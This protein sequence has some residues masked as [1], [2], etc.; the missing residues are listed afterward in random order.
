MAAN[1]PYVPLTSEVMEFAQMYC[2]NEANGKNVKN[3][4]KGEGILQSDCDEQLLLAIP[5]SSAVR[6]FSIIVEGPAS[7]AP[8]H[9]K[10]FI[11]QP[12][13]D[14]QNAESTPAVQEISL[15]PQQTKEGAG[16]PIPLRF[17]KFQNVNRLLIF[18]D[19]NHGGEDQ[20]IISRLQVIGSPIKVE[21]TR[22][23]DGHSHNH[24]DDN[25]DHDL[26]GQM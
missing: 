15:T 17:V 24:D 25:T 3:L 10:I 5:Y 26:L 19:K 2:L 1:S 12:S 7:N 16:Q 21:G 22:M 20:T 9:M 4:M 18:V 11:N 8:S 13:F 6:I 23:N 14:F